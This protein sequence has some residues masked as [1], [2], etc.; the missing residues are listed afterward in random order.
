M[1]LK[2][3][4]AS[5]LNVAIN[6]KQYKLPKPII[7]LKMLPEEYM[8]YNYDFFELHNSSKKIGRKC[9]LREE[10]IYTSQ[11]VAETLKE[12]IDK[13]VRGYEVEKV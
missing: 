3:I 1:Q 4:Y 9:E 12:I 6:G 10:I 7:E 2:R 5:A 11:G 8:A 13:I